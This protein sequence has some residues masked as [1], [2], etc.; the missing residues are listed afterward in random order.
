MN[1]PLSITNRRWTLAPA[2]QAR[3]FHIHSLHPLVA[4]CLSA[5]VGSA[6]V[7]D[8]LRPDAAHLHDPHTM[9]GMARAVERLKR[10][11]AERQRVRIVTDYDV[12]G[13]TSS[14]ILQ[15][16]FRLLG[17][18]DLV[19]YHI[20]NRFK[21]G[22]GFSVVAAKKAAEDGVSVIVTA[23]IGV[24]DHAA[25]TAAAEAGV[26]V[27]ICDHHLPAGE[28][29]PKDAYAVLCPPQK[30]CPYPNKSLAACGVSLKLAQAMLP[31]S[32]RTDKILR[33][34][35]K[36][37]AIGTIA[38]VVDLSGLENRA[39][40]T[41][42]LEQ[43]RLGPNAPGLQALLDI[44][45]LSDGWIDASDIG[46]RV[47]PRINAAGRL[48][49]A[50]T[51]IELFA[52]R[53]RDRAYLLARELDGLNKK[54]QEIER[55]LVEHCLADLEARE[56]EL[57]HFV[58]LA[59]QESAGWHRGVVGIVASRIRDRLH[60]PAAIISISQGSARGSI[61]S[62]PAI[63]S[64]QALESASDILEKFGG[65]PAAAGFSIHPD[66]IP[67]L[68]ERLDAFARQA[69][70]APE[71]PPLQLDADCS[72]SDISWS[73]VNALQRLGPHG[74]GNPRP[75]LWVRGVRPAG[76]RVFAQKHLKF[77]VGS[78]EAIWWK[79]A[80]YINELHGQ[81]D[82][83]AEPGINRWQG[84]TTVQLTVVDAVRS[85]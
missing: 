54:R 10:A 85:V 17:C 64:V 44:S 11:V 1:S 65:H 40:V 70:S 50:N 74:K 43:L 39:I 24:K 26:D 72:A 45:G 25:V 68:A 62:T 35:M 76:L 81:V 32:P 48:A 3:R 16:L 49:G 30:G 33:S 57:P 12:D 31:P 53:S 9:L 18:G 28:S 63:H 36:V 79:G 8:W 14:L 46:Y 47:S 77:R 82:L 75:L 38:D 80:Q 21:E 67:A 84:N 78:V 7:A 2:D 51:I 42:G 34:M 56:G 19:D 15:N 55:E 29:V 13:T 52:A 4:R 66:L 20:P 71:A 83:A 73:T 22:Y 58:V 69:A 37:A 59:G 5:R 6:D 61:R 60:R 41:L 27:V 23:D